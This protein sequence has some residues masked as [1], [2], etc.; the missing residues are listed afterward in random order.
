MQRTYWYKVRRVGVLEA[1]SVIGWQ[2]T[3][4]SAAA[5]AKLK[6]WYGDRLA[7]VYYE[8]EDD[9]QVVLYSKL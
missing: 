3:L 6:A 4:N 1:K 2:T 7:L 9:E 5:L 8:T